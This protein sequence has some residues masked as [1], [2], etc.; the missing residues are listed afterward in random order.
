MT[1]S[2]SPLLASLLLVACPP[3]GTSP[4]CPLTPACP[5]C[6]S[7]S[8]TDW[9]A[10]TPTPPTTGGSHPPQYSDGTLSLTGGTG[11]NTVDD[12]TIWSWGGSPLHE[13]YLTS[14]L[15]AFTNV[16]P[17]RSHVVSNST[18]STTDWDSHYV[19]S[20]G[21]NVKCSPT[22][23]SCL[24]ESDYSYEALPVASAFPVNVPAGAAAR[25]THVVA[26]PY[27]GTTCPDTAATMGTESSAGWIYRVRA[28][29]NGQVQW[30]D[31][32]VLASGRTKPFKC[33]G[34]GSTPNDYL[35]EVEVD[36]DTNPPGPQRF[37]QQLNGSNCSVTPEPWCGACT[38]GS[39]E[40]VR[41]DLDW[42]EAQ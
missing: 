9:R 29:I 12:G 31:M 2:L 42:W 7:P 41:V 26:Q 32:W 40:Y 8:W 1:L 37:V 14:H 30:T 19:K 22:D 15:G 17:V 10:A 33:S 36:A 20:G 13:G 28:I 4:P 11:S 25:V 18:P 21:N 24:A 39:C 16:V 3:T 38:G 23:S 27:S 35:D 6:V 34:T 5:A